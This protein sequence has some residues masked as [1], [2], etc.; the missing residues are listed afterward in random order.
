MF[1]RQQNRLGNQKSSHPRIVKIESENRRGNRVFVFFLFGNM[2]KKSRFKA[3]KAPKPTLNEL[4]TKF[5]SKE[6]KKRYPELLRFG[7]MIKQLLYYGETFGKNEKL[8]GN[9][10]IIVYVCCVIKTINNVLLVV[11]VLI[12]KH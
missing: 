9:D 11:K 7:K 2:S 4:Q 3:S 12:L 8:N 6:H 1:L 10:M 5:E